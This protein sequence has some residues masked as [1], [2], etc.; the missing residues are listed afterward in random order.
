MAFKKI[1]EHIILAAER[2]PTPCHRFRI[3]LH[4][5]AG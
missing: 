4:T 2:T 1:Q 5:L 3:N